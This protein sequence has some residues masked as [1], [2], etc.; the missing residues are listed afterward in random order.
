MI[1]LRVFMSP[2]GK[3]AADP[4]LIEASSIGGRDL[5]LMQGAVARA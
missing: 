2:E 1:R 4:V 5:E 3:L